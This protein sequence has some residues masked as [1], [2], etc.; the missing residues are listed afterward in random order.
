MSTVPKSV[1]TPIIID[2]E[3]SGFGVGSY[4]IEIG[5]ALGDASLHCL[6]VK[7]LDDWTHWDREGE[8][9]HR[10]SRRTLMRYGK[11]ARDV[12]LE[13][14]TLLRG[15]VAYSDGWGVDFPWL[16]RLYDSVSMVPRFRLETLASILSESQKRAW[17]D[18]KAQTFE[19]LSFQRHRASNDA[20]VL[21]LTYIK[22]LQSAQC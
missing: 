7:P 15:Q 12:A 13:L 3:A 14:N 5:V 11:P 9:L 19:D 16:S 21:Q 4:P 17:E 2:I 8:A 1:A 10:I 22:T 18:V 6:L 20:R